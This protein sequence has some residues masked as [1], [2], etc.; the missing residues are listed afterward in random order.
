M[1]GDGV[2]PVGLNISKSAP[3]TVDA[4][5]NLTYTITYGNTGGTDA[6]N[7]VITDPIPSNASFVSATGGGSVVGSDV[8][9][10]F[11]TLVAGVTGQTVTFTVTAGPTGSV[12]NTGYSIR[13]DGVDPTTGADVT[14]TIPFRPWRR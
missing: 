2:Q 11:G 4:G 3:A 6:T 9:W 12:V 5:A 13:S 10:E 8:V 7:L 14:T 1:R